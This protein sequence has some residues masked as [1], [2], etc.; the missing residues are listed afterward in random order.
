MSR[1]RNMVADEILDG[2]ALEEII[3]EDRRK[4]KEENQKEERR[5]GKKKESLFG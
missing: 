3:H 1:K 4:S 5:K 2:S